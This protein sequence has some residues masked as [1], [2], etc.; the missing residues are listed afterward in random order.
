M[1]VWKKISRRDRSTERRI[2]R[3]YLALRSLNALLIKIYI[4]MGYVQGIA[5]Y[6]MRERV[7]GLVL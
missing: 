1:I 2:A 5:P 4:K 3:H 6:F 7:D